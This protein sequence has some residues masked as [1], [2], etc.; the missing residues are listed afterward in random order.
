MRLSDFLWFS[1]LAGVLAMVA[2]IGLTMVT[3]TRQ[4]TQAIENAMR[5]RD[6]AQAKGPRAQP[7]SVQQGLPPACLPT[8]GSLADCANWV[9]AHPPKGGAVVDACAADG[10]MLR[11]CLNHLVSAQGELKDIQN[12]FDAKAPVFAS[13]CS[14]AAPQTL[15]GLIVLVGR[16]KSATDSTLD[17]KP[18]KG[19]TLEQARAVRITVCGRLYRPSAPIDFQI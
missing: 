17:Y 14:A 11:D 2:W 12:P 16:P 6:W 13:S 1:T 9:D 4:T 5:I 8:Q 18:L 19:Q 15:G 7:V 3:E 10:G